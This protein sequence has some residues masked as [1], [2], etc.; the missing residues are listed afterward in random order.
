MKEKKIII[1]G[2]IGAVVGLGVA[3]AVGG[4]AFKKYEEND[5]G[6]PLL[7][8]SGTIAERRSGGSKK[9]SKSRK[10]IMKNT[11]KT[12]KQNKSKM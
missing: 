5:E 9:N 12:R 4:Y 3:V 6:D 1:L 2:I 10:G 8:Y 7:N 11:K